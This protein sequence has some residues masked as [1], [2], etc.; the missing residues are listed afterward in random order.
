MNPIEAAQSVWGLCGLVLGTLIGVIYTLERV[1]AYQRTGEREH[2]LNAFNIP[3]FF[4]IVFLAYK[5][6]NVFWFVRWGIHFLLAITGIATGI[7]I[8][9]LVK[10]KS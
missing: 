1:M 6:Q 5:F 8:F 9:S 4:I 3:V 10:T 2:I 7:L